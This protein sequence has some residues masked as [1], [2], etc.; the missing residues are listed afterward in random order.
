MTELT[1][2]NW[3]PITEA[4]TRLSDDEIKELHKSVPNWQVVEINNLKHLQ[5]HFEFPNFEQ[6]LEFVY[7][8]GKKALEQKHY[9]KLVVDVTYVTVDWVTHDLHGLHKNDFVMALRVDDMLSRW[10]LI[11]GEKD[12]VEEASE[13]S[14]PASDPPGY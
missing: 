11:S 8:V 6:S 9:P 13:E 12:A 10:E 2:Q 4:S 3:E 7:E 5:R 1:A 14:F